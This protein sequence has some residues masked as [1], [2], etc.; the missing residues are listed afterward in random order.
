MQE[1]GERSWVRLCKCLSLLLN[2]EERRGGREKPGK[3]KM[4]EK[5]KLRW[6]I[7]VG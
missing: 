6:G 7:L 2:F 3:I 4:E 1:Y 5:V